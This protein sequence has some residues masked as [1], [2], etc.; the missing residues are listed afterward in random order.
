MCITTK[1]VLHFVYCAPCVKIYY[2]QRHWDGVK[3]A[4]QCAKRGFIEVLVG[5]IVGEGEQTRRYYKKYARCM[6]L[7][8]PHSPLSSSFSLCVP[9]L[10]YYLVCYAIEKG[11]DVNLVNK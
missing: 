8:P 2:L 5:V 1:Y 6:F 7:L 4:V 9:L 11:F 3:G 10:I